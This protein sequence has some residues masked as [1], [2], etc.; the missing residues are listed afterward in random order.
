MDLLCT[1][2][3]VSSSRESTQLD[4]LSRILQSRY[5]SK[6]VM[7]PASVDQMTVLKFMI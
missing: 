4:S 5:G 1:A 2:R 7:L 6:F 3:W